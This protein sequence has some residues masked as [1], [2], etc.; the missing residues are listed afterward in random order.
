MFTVLPFGLSTA[1][2]MFIKLLRPLVRYWRTRGL[3]ILVYLD[4]GLCTVAGRQKAL[5]A[6]QLVSATLTKAGFVSHPTK[7]KWVPTQ[8]L[9]WL[10]LIIDLALG[11]IEVPGEKL[12]DLQHRLVL[13][14]RLL[15]FPPGT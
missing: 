11:Q 15:G 9:P 5:D 13:H 14:V 3:R 1:C 2:Y 10:G 7:C 6:S 4:D 12:V 8:R